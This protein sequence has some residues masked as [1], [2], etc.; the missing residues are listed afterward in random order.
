M[1]NMLSWFCPYLLCKRLGNR[2]SE[3]TVTV[4]WSAP[5]SNLSVRFYETTFFKAFCGLKLENSLLWTH[6][7][8][9]QHSF[10]LKTF[11]EFENIQRCRVLFQA[12]GQPPS[13]ISKTFERVREHS[14]TLKVRGHWG[15][16]RVG[17]HSELGEFEHIR[18]IEHIRA[19]RVRA[20]SALWSSAPNTVAATGRAH[21]PFWAH[22]PVSDRVFSKP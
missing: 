21:S 16:E 19:E 17:T 1:Q 11:W 22:S 7:G 4:S 8:F 14:T 15:T 12:P 18:E 20:H 5:L 3:W 2:N 9:W 13:R 10:V 6:S